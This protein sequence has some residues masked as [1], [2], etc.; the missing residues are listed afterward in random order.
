NANYTYLDWDTADGRLP[1]R[2]RH[3]GSISLNYSQER[4]TANLTTFMVGRRD[5]FRAASPFGNT[6]TAGYV[7]TDLAS[8]YVFPLRVPL[9]KEIAVFGKVQNLFNKKYEDAN[10]F[11]A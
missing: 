8:S 4:V 2:P 1:R 6:T 11:R 10:G 7:R 9:V 3:R 5:D